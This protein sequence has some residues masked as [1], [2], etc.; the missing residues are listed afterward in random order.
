MVS[1]A[2]HAVIAGAGVAGL[3]TACRL[4]ATGWSTTVLE[5]R[6][7]LLEGGRAIL[8]QPNGLAALEG[9]GALEHV[10]ERGIVL[11]RVVFET[12]AGRR[13][14]LYDYGELDHP[15]AYALEIRPPD[16]RGALAARLAELGAEPPRLSCEV[17][18]LRRRGDAVAG[19]H[20]RGPDGAERELDAACV[21]GADGPESSVRQALGIRARR[22]ISPDTYVLGVVD[23]PGGGSELTVYCGPGFADGVV[24][25]RDG[26]YLWDRVTDENR[27]AVSS[28]DVSGWRAVYEQRL[29]AGHEVPPAVVSWDQL[30]TVRTCP[31]VP[32]ARIATGAA[33]AGDAA[34]MV[35]PHSAQGA[36]LALED[37]VALGDALERHSGPEPVPQ[38]ALRAYAGPRHRKLRRYMLG[39]LWVARSFDA[40][41]P[42][43]RAIR[44]TGF[45][46]A[47][48]GPLRRALHR[49]Q[50]GLG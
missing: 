35:H 24:P 47:R 44:A 12:T 49:R 14:A 45:R 37:A 34:G 5:R 29:P 16:L 9:L 26:V 31:F 38:S 20:Y 25:L 19:A 1:G 21:V 36:N 15:H 7:D 43:W 23:G 42:L 40:P 11:S 39:S 2:P 6:A 22:F 28:R 4:A 32:A 18:G 27:E 3:A 41:N 48:I 33:L 46:S 17:T 10:R 8:L 13:L 50:A 30:T